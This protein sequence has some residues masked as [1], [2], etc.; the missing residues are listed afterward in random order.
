MK[1][2]NIISLVVVLVC[3]VAAMLA[4]TGAMAPHV[5]I[6]QAI[7]RTNDTVQVPGFI[8]KDSVKYDATK[9]ELRFDVLGMDPSGAR[10]VIS[11]QKM[12]VVYKQAKPENFDSAETVEAVGTYR[13]GLFHAENLLVKCPSKYGDS[14][15]TKVAQR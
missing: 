14:K 6:P 1:P 7:T 4:L 2:A 10:K 5:S 3:M 11:D 9:G 15:P 8:V 13:E 12:T